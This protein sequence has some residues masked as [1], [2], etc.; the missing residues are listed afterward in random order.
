MNVVV[1]T[2]TVIFLFF[3]QNSLGDVDLEIYFSFGVNMLENDVH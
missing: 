3:F 2:F 1:L